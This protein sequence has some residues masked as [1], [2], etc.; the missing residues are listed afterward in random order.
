MVEVEEVVG[1]VEVVKL[2]EV[3]VGSRKMAA[4]WVVAV[5]T[6]VVVKVGE[7]RAK[8]MAARV[9]VGE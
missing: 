3:G 2:L 5:M 8:E 4:S 1:V 7:V 6:E 9:K